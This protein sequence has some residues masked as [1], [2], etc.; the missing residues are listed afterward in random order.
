[1]RTYGFEKL[2]VWVDSK[3]LAL[4]IYRE[5]K[6]FPADEK[7]GLVSQMRRAIISVPSNIAEGSNRNTKK[8][9]A[10][11]Y[12][13][14]YSSLMEVLSQAIIS[15]ELGYLTTD[16][17]EQIRNEIEKISNKI[18]ALRKAILEK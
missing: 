15:H 12:G 14:A 8:D 2:Q 7:Y 17:Y 18:N 13:I 3:E 11:F 6:T 9:Q 5:T 4:L 1:M 10:H 16:K